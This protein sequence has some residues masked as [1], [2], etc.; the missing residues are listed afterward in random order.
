M[1]FDILTKSDIVLPSFD[2]LIIPWKQF[3]DP[4]ELTTH[5]NELLYLIVIQLMI[6]MFPVEQ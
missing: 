4:R 2:G 5:L 6:L 1:F 3:A